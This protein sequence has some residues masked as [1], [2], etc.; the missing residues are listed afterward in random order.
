M[1]PATPPLAFDS[2]AAPPPP[3]E[4]PPTAAARN[5]RCVT[6][7][8]CPV[9][10][11]LGGRR[12]AQRARALHRKALLEEHRCRRIARRRARRT[13]V[14]TDLD[15]HPPRRGLTAREPPVV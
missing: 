4:R 12:A 8:G 2:I 13:A 3:H 9:R 1:A 6:A 15:R 14:D 10:C 5:Q 11:L 7:F